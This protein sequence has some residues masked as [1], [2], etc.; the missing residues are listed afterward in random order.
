MSLC[1]N[2]AHAAGSPSEKPRRSGCTLVLHNVAQASQ[3]FDPSSRTVVNSADVFGKTVFVTAD[4]TYEPQVHTG[5]LHHHRITTW[6]A[7]AYLMCSRL[8]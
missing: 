8:A 2:T 6:T 7:L 5:G 4:G 1:C 3:D